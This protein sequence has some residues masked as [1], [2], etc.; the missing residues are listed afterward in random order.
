MTLAVSSSAMPTAVAA[1][2]GGDFSRRLARQEE[3]AIGGVIA[4][5]DVFAAAHL[6]GVAAPAPVQLGRRAPRGFVQRE[7]RAP[8]RAVERLDHI[9]LADVALEQHLLGLQDGGEEELVVRGHHDDAG[10]LDRGCDVCRF[11]QVEAERLLGHQVL[12][13]LGCGD[14][15]VA[16]QVM[17]QRDVH[18]VD[19]RVGEQVGEVR[20]RLYL[21]AILRHALGHGPRRHIRHCHDLGAVGDSFPAF[22]M[23]VHNPATADQANADCHCREFLIW[24]RNGRINF[25]HRPG[26]AQLPGRSFHLAFHLSARAKAD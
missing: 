26:S 11:G 12:A 5:V 14:D 16:V 13:R 4:G 7:R 23:R 6:G 17:W 20:V 8:L 24:M 15:G 2:H 21:A 22:H 9:D 1:H 18:G 25:A 10:G 3:Q 19:V